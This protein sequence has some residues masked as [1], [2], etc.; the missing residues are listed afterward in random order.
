MHAAGSPA[1]CCK[2]WR[3]LSSGGVLSPPGCVNKC[4]N[5]LS[6]S[7]HPRLAR[8][9]LRFASRSPVPLA[10]VVVAVARA[11]TRARQSRPSATAREA[12]P[13]DNASAA[14][15]A[16]KAAPACLVWRCSSA[17]RTYRLSQRTCRA[18]STRCC[19]MATT[20]CS[21]TPLLVG[22]SLCVLSFVSS[23]LLRRLP[24]VVSV[25]DSQRPWPNV[26]QPG[27]HQCA[28]TMSW[29]L[30]A[31]SAGT[32]CD[33]GFVGFITDASQPSR[34]SPP[35]TL[36]TPPTPSTPCPMC[37]ACPRCRP[38]PTRRNTSRQQ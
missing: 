37:R 8:Y 25:P 16:P 6:C 13:T 3:A 15:G 27:A 35:S 10:G 5:V 29:Q 19:L 21:G 32:S 2:S 26:Q 33:V 18:A 11:L 28:C 24:V 38:A 1:Q 31:G 12:D 17:L 23:R 7:P 30:A 9:S 34:P 4:A 22:A 14:R 36:S 20:A